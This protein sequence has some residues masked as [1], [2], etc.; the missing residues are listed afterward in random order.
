MAIQVQ[1]Q[2]T[3]LEDVPVVAARQADGGVVRSKRRAIARAS[4]AFASR[5]SVMSNTSRLRSEEAR[6]LVITASI[7]SCARARTADDRL[8]NQADGEKRE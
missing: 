1:P 4:V 2:R 5:L 3:R 6:Q 7:A 8:P